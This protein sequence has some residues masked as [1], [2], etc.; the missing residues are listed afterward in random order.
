MSNWS[1]RYVNTMK[2]FK[3]KPAASHL[4]RTEALALKPVKSRHVSE[5]RLETGEVVIE[6]PMA[7]RP[8]I[9]AVTKRLGKSPQDLVQIKKLQLDAL[10]TFVWD[11]VDGRHTVRRMIN[12]FA[13]AHR[14]EKREAEVSVTR[15]IR[16]L[17][18]RGLL[19]S[20]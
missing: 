19:G 18:R 13:E 14:L 5:S 1:I 16:E 6:Y 8:L 7:V 11:L 12:I 15:F 3:R 17:G 9:A 20:R 2:A 4:T 10:G